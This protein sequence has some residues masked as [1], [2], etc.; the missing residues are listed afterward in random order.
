[1]ARKIIAFCNQ[2]GGTGKTTSTVN[3]SAE[4]KKR[5][6][7]VLVID[8]DFQCNCT[9]QAGGQPS[10]KDI[11]AVLDGTCTAAE[12]IQHRPL[13]DL[14]PAT[15]QLHVID[16]H[17]PSD[18]GKH[19]RLKKALEPV[20]DEYDF[21][22][23]DTHPDIYTATLMGVVAAT[24]VIIPCDP[25]LFSASGLEDELNFLS[26]VKEYFNPTLKIDG[27]LF[28][29]TMWFKTIKDVV[30]DFYDLCAAKDVPVFDISI[31]NAA[32]VTKVQ[33]RQEA[34]CSNLS[35]KDVAHDYA[36]LVDRILGNGME[37]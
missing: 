33:V 12:A 21:I 4:L 6:F 8:L 7:Q 29:R 15:K 2:K 34:L 32:D 22:I 30:S 3:V 23:L 20:Q 35:K 31:R 26:Q 9:L 36:L 25:S 24:N 13:F 18:L 19:L 10:D 11:L 1:V 5:G 16:S 14:I 28:T 37:E 27:V 17:F